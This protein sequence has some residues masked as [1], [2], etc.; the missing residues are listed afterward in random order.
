MGRRREINL[1][2]VNSL[3][4]TG[5]D[6]N[7]EPSYSPTP[8][9]DYLLT[10]ARILLW[11]FLF[12]F[13]TTNNYLNAKYFNE[14]TDYPIG[15]TLKDLIK[16]IKIHIAVLLWI[17]MKFLSQNLKPFPSL[18]GGFKP[19]KNHAT[20][21]PAWGCIT[22]SSFCKTG[23]LAEKTA[24]LTPDIFLLLDGPFLEYSH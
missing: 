2:H 12:C 17:A 21:L 22:I 10:M 3:N 9:V 23:A 6:N 5:T 7:E 19:R 15:S 16:K 24:S 11:L 13:M 1:K 14:S 20:V 18:A 4:G 8:F